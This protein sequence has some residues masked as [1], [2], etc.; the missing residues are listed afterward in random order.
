MNESDGSPMFT[1]SID[2]FEVPC[3][4]KIILNDIEILDSTLCR[5]CKN[6]MIPGAMQQTPLIS[7]YFAI[8]I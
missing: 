8:S 5:C 7:Q 4:I 6:S 2:D 3:N 1:I